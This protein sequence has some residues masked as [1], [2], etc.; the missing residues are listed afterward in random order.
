VIPIQQVTKKLRRRKYIYEKTGTEINISET[1]KKKEEKN[2]HAHKSML[3]GENGTS[4]R[5]NE[6][7]RGRN[8]RDAIKMRC[9][10][11]DLKKCTWTESIGFISRGRLTNRGA[12]TGPKKKLHSGND[13]ETR[14]S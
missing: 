10:S 13:Q 1:R 11:G 3:H 2:V 9:Y 8:D 6:Q 14:E 7:K 12:A 4:R 5:L